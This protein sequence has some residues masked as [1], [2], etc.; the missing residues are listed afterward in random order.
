[1][2]RNNKAGDRVKNIIV[3]VLLASLLIVGCDD[4]SRLTSTGSSQPP[5]A[6]VT[7]GNQRLQ[8]VINGYQWSDGNRS[9]VAD[10]AMSGLGS[11]KTENR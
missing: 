9:S 8:M 3:P 11:N 4:A 5:Q 7:I 1:M 2:E 6:S 10:V